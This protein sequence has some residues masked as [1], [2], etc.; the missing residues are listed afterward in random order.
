MEVTWSKQDKVRRAGIVPLRKA[1]LEAR[2]I[3]GTA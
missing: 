2:D 3:G 1:A